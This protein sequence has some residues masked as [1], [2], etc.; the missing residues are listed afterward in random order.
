[1]DRTTLVFGVE[2]WRGL[3]N[4]GVLDGGGVEVESG[5]GNL[6]LLKN[7]S[8]GGPVLPVPVA[9]VV[10][11]R[12]VLIWTIGIHICEWGSVTRWEIRST[13]IGMLLSESDRIRVQRVSRYSDL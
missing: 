5:G 9:P 6:W 1:M 11:P 8:I 10:D 12:G 2:I 4:K 3:L 7:A 13:W